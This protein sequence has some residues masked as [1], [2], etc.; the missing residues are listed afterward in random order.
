MTPR[1]YSRSEH[2]ISRQAIS[3]SSLRVL[4]TLIDAGFEAYIVGGGVRDLLLGLKPKDFDIATNATPEQVKALFRNSRIIGRRFRIVHVHFGKEIIEVSTF[5][6]HNSESTAFIEEETMSRDEAKLESVR[7]A[8]GRILRDNVYGTIEEDVQRRDFTVN[9]LYYTVKN[10]VVHDYVDGMADIDRRCLRMI[11]DPAERYKEDPVRV[12]RAIRLAAKLDFSITRET[13]SPI[14][15]C[16]KLLD[17]IPAARLFDEFLK[18]FLAGNSLQTFRLLQQ[19]DVFRHLFPGTHS[20][21]QASP[22]TYQPLLEAA[23]AST[24]AR[25]TEGKPV[26]PIFLLAVLLWPA[27][28][29]QLHHLPHRIS[30]IADLQEAGQMVIDE[31][32][33]R[34]AIPKRFSFPV[35]EIWE[36]QHRFGER[37]GK[38]A[39]L[40]MHHKRFRAA[41]D[42]L[43]LREQGGEDLQGLGQWW[44]QYQD[45]QPD[46]R[47]AMI[48]ALQSQ[49]V[50]H[51]KPRRRKVKSRR[52]QAT[53]A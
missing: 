52:P 53:L 43:L 32:V 34:I 20:A 36:L 15:A 37:R 1:V 28:Q 30:P 46:Q 31:Q 42:F 7:A 10:F 16:A 11:G 23:F 35:R 29:Y 5:R 47:N 26:T 6:A 22:G 49:A 33:T 27:L 14:P 25:V 12:L 39:E 41:Y 3:P 4:Y 45:A 8:S 38:R 51:A 2:G 17:A 18:L 13:A 48:N 40:L 9:A 21:L 24:D 19:Y 44:S 50:P